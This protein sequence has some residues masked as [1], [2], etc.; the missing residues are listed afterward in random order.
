MESRAAQTVGR[1]FFAQ[2]G[3]KTSAFAGP[4]GKWRIKSYNIVTKIT[5]K[6]QKQGRDSVTK[7]T[8]ENEI[9]LKLS[10]T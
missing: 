8:K 1:R 9:P 10:F 6:L 4:I 3:E 5:E 2:K 7:F